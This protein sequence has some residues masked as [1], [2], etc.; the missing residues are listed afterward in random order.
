MEK[1]IWSIVVI[2]IVTWVFLNGGGEGGGGQGKNDSSHS[3]AGSW[4]MWNELF[5]KSIYFTLRLWKQLSA[6]S[7][8]EGIYTEDMYIQVRWIIPWGFFL[9]R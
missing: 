1:N 3:D 5:F 4:I 7:S 2:C 6:I 9:Y 8:G